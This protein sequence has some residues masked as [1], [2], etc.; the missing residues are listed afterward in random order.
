MAGFQLST[1][2]LIWVSTEAVEERELLGPVRQVV[3]RVQIDRDPA[4]GRLAALGA[5]R[6]FTTG[7]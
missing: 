7:C 5:T 3:G 4:G 1:N 6:G 2:G